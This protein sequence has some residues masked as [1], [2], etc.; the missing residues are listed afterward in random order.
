M[1]ISGSSLL[2]RI[3]AFNPSCS[4]VASI[5]AGDVGAPVVAML[6]RGATAALVAHP[7]V[8]ST[9]LE[10][11]AARKKACSSNVDSNLLNSLKGVDAFRVNLLF[12]KHCVG[13]RPHP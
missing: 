1:A 2:T 7:T 9:L 11:A 12:F 3:V 6:S 4:I 8:A 5:E 10:A 13:Y